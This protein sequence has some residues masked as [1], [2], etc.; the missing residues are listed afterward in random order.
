M[1]KRSSRH[2]ARLACL[3]MTN[4]FAILRLLASDRGA[5]ADATASVVFFTSTNML[6]NQHG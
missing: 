2:D 1:V 6:S 4:T 5:S 3:T